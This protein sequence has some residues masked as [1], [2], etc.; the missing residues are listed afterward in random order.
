M[1]PTKRLNPV[2]GSQ[3]ESGFDEYFTSFQQSGLT[4]SPG[5][6]A[7]GGAHQRHL[8]FQ[9]SGLTQSPGV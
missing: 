4:Q 1:F 9:Q 5:D 2:A 6:L 8:G 3:D 7:V